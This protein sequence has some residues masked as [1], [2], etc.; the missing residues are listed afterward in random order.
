MSFLVMPFPA[1]GQLSDWVGEDTL[2]IE[3]M[4]WCLMLVALVIA[5]F[6]LVTM[7]LTRW[8]DRRATTKSLI[9][10]LLVHISCGLG[11]VI[12]H[13]APATVARE[14]PGESPQRIQI[15]HLA[16]EN[17]T[18]SQA[19]DQAQ[20]PVWEQLPTPEKTEIAR[21]ER[22]VNDIPPVENPQRPVAEI[23]QPEIKL[24]KTPTPA[25]EPENTPTPE[26]PNVPT[27]KAE[28]A[29][30]PEINE[31]T[32]EIRPEW[33]TPATPKTRQQVA[34]SGQPIQ[35]FERTRRRRAVDTTITKNRELPD[36]TP[37][38]ENDLEPT[39]RNQRLE[40]N[41]R[42]TAD[43]RRGSAPETTNQIDTQ[44]VSETNTKQPTNPSKQRIVRSS[45]SSS[46]K[47]QNEDD[48]RLPTRMRKSLPGDPSKSTDRDVSIR[49]DDPSFSSPD[50][51]RPEVEST[52]VA[53]SRPA[54]PAD[55]PATYRLRS[56]ERRRETAR[57]Y[58]GT[59]KSERAVEASLSWLARNQHEVGF[60]DADRYGSGLV[61]T[62]D[63]GTDRRN[64]GKYSDTGVTALA[65][66]SFLGAG[67]T[68]EEGQYSN[69]VEKALR[70]L[71]NQQRDDG[72]LGGS[73]SYY[74]GMYCH[75]MVTYA[76][77]EAYGM[78]SDSE[79]KTRLR[80]PLERGIAYILANQND[81]DGGW[82]YRKGQPGDMSMFGW[83]LM[84]LK[85]AEIAGI[86]IPLKAKQQ[87]VQFL[88]NRSLGRRR[89]LA[90][91]L[92]KMKPS[93]TMTAEALFCKQMLGIEREH[94]ASLQAVAYLRLRQPRLSQLNHYYWYYGTLAMSQFGGEPWKEWNESLRDILVIEQRTTGEF[95]GSWD[96]KG[97]WGRFG[98]RLYSTALSTLALET[99][100][101][102][103]PLYKMGGRY[104]EQP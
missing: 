89:G 40:S 9:F 36:L 93:P 98:G 14:E 101:R 92:E 23:T 69:E 96:P 16:E 8:G 52:E 103:L 51:P 75:G 60:W 2:S 49:V 65:V 64:A 55:I 11:I 70:W 35:K 95:A 54:A 3:G 94:P 32:N 100:Y 87:M 82:R 7:L 80:K 29:Q 13:P 25:T 81:K 44:F 62:D 85:S 30:S 78:Q 12:V 42:E 67:Y 90:G 15:K 57:R 88:K 34:R 53:R 31:S 56:L 73:A 22:P 5:T 21:V 63:N 26:R 104:D 59:E 68:A 17:I 4:L 91:Y 47:S 10:S 71:A 20:K 46:R 83:Q 97:P 28:T 1:I 102:F 18:E 39:T 27:S 37:A 99:Y 48:T 6:D 19:T 50:D 45:R 61:K 41:E 86:E 79:F 66:L 84:A 76:L 24:P 72:Y 74:A 33:K 38:T 43:S 58:G 77:A